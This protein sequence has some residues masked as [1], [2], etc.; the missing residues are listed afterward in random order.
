MHDSSAALLEAARTKL[1]AFDAPVLLRIAG[2]IRLSCRA[3]G[4]DLSYAQVLQDLSECDS[5]WWKSCE[6]RSDGCLVCWDPVIH[7]LLVPIL[8]LHPAII[9]AQPHPLQPHCLPQAALFALA[10]IRGG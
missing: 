6:I 3:L 2:F 9:S 1:L 7:Q 8:Q 4:N 5:E 10:G